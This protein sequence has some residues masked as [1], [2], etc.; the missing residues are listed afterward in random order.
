MADRPGR[1]QLSC[2]SEETELI[3]QGKELG[4]G[5]LLREVCR[6]R[7]NF[8]YMARASIGKLQLEKGLLRT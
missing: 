1:N 8:C 4:E 6:L 3:W 7:Q 2:S 5:F